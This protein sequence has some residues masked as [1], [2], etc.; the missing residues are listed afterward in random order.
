MAWVSLLL[1]GLRRVVRWA[2]DALCL[3]LGYL[4]WEG[5]EGHSRDSTGSV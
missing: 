1:L 2:R 3:T 5:R 4:N